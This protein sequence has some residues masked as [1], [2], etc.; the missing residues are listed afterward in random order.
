MRRRGKFWFERLRAWLRRRLSPAPLTEL[1]FE[2]KVVL[3][4]DIGRTADGARN[5]IVTF[6]VARALSGSMPKYVIVETRIPPAPEL[7]PGLSCLVH[8]TCEAGAIFDGL[9]PATVCGVRDARI[10]LAAAAA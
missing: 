1:V 2:G 5:V 4:R 9:A 10:Q 8:A 7:Q 6:L 3:V